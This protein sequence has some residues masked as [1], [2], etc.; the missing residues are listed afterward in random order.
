MHNCGKRMLEQAY[1]NGKTLLVTL[2]K[3]KDENGSHSYRTPYYCLQ[4]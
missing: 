1:S 2:K 4:F 3:Q